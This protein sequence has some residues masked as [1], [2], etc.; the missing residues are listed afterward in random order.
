MRRLVSLSAGLLLFYCALAVAAF[1]TAWRDPTD[2]WIGSDV[3]PILFIWSLRWIPFSL[4]HGHDPF[5][6]N[7]IAYPHGINIMWNTTMPL[8]GLVLTP[9][10]LLLGAVF[11]YNVLATL[12]LALSAWCA[13]FAFRRYTH[14][15]PAAVGGLLYGF[16]PFTFAQQD[17]PQIALA[18]FPPIVFLLLD[19]IL[20]RQRRS[21]IVLGLLLSVATILQVLVG[22]EI[23]AATAL[24][25]AVGVALLALLN[26]REVRP[27][28]EYAAR[29]LSV[30]IGVGLVIGAYPLAVQFFG[31]QRL[32][33]PVQ[34]ENTFVQDLLAFVVPTHRQELHFAATE[35]VTRT[36]TGGSDVDGYVGIP[37]LALAAFV[38]WRYRAD[39]LVR[40]AA[41]FGLA[42]AVLSLGPRLHVQGHSLPIRLP[43]VVPQHI[44]VL[45]NV[46]PTRLAVFTLF[47]L[48]L[49]LAVFLDRVRLPR[50]ALAAIVAAAFVPLIP[51]LPFL[52]QPKTPPRFFET[53]A[54]ELPDGS[55]ALVAPQA[56]LAGGAKPMLWQVAAGLR[57]KMPGAYAMSGTYSRLPLQRRINDIASDIRPPPPTPQQLHRFRCDVIRLDARTVI[58]GP[59]VDRERMIALFRAV[60]ARPPENV[61][62]VQLWRDALASARAHAR[63]CA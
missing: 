20:V 26:R 28:L 49:L 31:S 27:R 35:R 55:V 29:A 4:T 39:R 57:F 47:A 44:P 3:D 5:V 50:Y 54:P 8:A 12:S 1:W 25:A 41:A 2:R 17:H 14:P 43:W 61:G 51:D 52:S 45:E 32:T 23:A 22:E 6:T 7:W 30:A 46:L 33:G 63:S 15:L 21:P 13:Y 10:T 34:P 60:L 48:A 62:G 56:G 42:A 9:V 19:E 59:T 37:L 40:F 36:F 53:G 16:G 24:L 18:V 58:V 38:V 11:S